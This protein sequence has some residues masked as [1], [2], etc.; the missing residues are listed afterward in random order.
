M[1]IP[2]GLCSGSS[3]SERKRM[4]LPLAISSRSWRIA[5]RAAAVTWAPVVIPYRLLRAEGAARCR[6]T[7]QSMR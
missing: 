7:A 4:V 6:A 3:R 2:S 1:T 5:S